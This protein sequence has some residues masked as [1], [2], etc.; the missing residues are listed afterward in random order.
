MMFVLAGGLSIAAAQCQDAALQAAVADQASKTISLVLFPRITNAD[1]V[2]ASNP[3]K[4]TIVDISPS[5]TAPPPQIASVVLAADRLYPNNFLSAS[6]DYTGTFDITRRYVLSNVDLTFNGCKP[7]NPPSTAVLFEL[8][9]Q[10]VL[11]STKANGEA[12]SDIYLAGQLEGSHKTRANQTAD[13]KVEIPFSHRFLGRDRDIAPFFNLKASNSKKSDADSLKFGGLIRSTYGFR[14]FGLRNVSWETDGRIEADRRFGNVNALWG[15]TLYLIPPLVG[16]SKNLKVLAFLQ[17]LVGFELGHNLKSPLKLAEDRTLARATAGG[18]LYL[19]FNTGNKYLDSI[20]FQTDYIRRWPLRSEVTFT[21]D[22]KGNLL[23]L[24]FGRNPR[25]YV[26]SK[27]EFNVNDF[28]GIA[29]GYDY[30]RLPPNFKLVDSHFTLG[31]V[32][33]KRIV[34][35]IK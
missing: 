3:G 14:H 11:V 4:W 34:R 32:Y 5:P 24:F 15:N 19:L 28:F 8:K 27:I 12:D 35:R 29:V 31:F 18:S 23:P 6:L 1:Q 21:E 26:T 20:S 2:V 22:D 7:P 33:K 25:D 9:K 10:S 13:I 30:G 17:P 16:E